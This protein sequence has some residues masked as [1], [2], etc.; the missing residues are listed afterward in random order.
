MVTIAQR[1]LERAGGDPGAHRQ[2]QITEGAPIWA[3]TAVAVAVPHVMLP[4]TGVTGIR[5]TS[6][7]RRT[8][9]AR[10]N[11]PYQAC[12]DGTERRPI[13]NEVI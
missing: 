11:S 9:T 7:A 3:A 12:V 10:P 4:N 1:R 2:H 13:T 6:L 8:I 5:S